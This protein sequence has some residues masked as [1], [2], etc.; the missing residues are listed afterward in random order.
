MTATDEKLEPELTETAG[1]LR[2]AG[3][4]LELGKHTPALFLEQDLIVVSLWRACK[5][6]RNLNSRARG[7]FPCGAKLNL[8]GGSCAWGSG[9]HRI[10]RENRRRLSLVKPL[11]YFEDGGHCDAS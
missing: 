8:L 3:V 7:E 4:R 6:F 11:A 1:R 5:A 9:D 2:A 10:E